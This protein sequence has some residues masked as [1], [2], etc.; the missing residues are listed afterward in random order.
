MTEGSVLAEIEKLLDG[1]ADDAARTRVVEWA[2]GRYA[3]TKTGGAPAV[4]PP[5]WIPMPYPVPTIW[6]VTC[7]EP[8]PPVITWSGTTL[9]NLAG[10]ASGLLSEGATITVSSQSKFS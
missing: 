5:T 1:L 6:P 2:R 7:R 9:P 8:N 10:I 4:N 3:S